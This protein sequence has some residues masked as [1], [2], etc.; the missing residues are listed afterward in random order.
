MSGSKSCWKSWASHF[1]SGRRDNLDLG[2]RIRL[3]V[4][5]QQLP[6][7]LQRETGRSGALPVGNAVS[8]FTASALGAFTALLGEH[9]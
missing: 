9:E 8:G 7:H 1:L 4:N 6:L 5:L 2:H 3:N